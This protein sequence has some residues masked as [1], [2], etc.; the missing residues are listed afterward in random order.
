MKISAVK[1][2]TFF[3]AIVIFLQLYIYSFRFNIFFQLFVL[4]GFFALEK[5]KISTSFFKTS[6]PLII[7]FTLGF[8]GMV[9]E[10]Y[11]L[12]NI[13]KDIFHFIKPV[14]AICI[15]YFFYKKINNFKL[16]V[17]TIIIT[18][19][20]SALLHYIIIIFFIKNIETVSNI[21]EH[22]TDNFME[23]IA[24]FFLA[25]YKKF[26]KDQLFQ[27]KILHR[28]IFGVL[29]TSSVLYFSRTMIVMAVLTLLTIYGYTIINRKGLRIAALL[30]I[31]TLGFYAFLFSIN[32]QRNKKGIDS[33]LYKVKNAP[34]EVFKTRIDRENHADLWDHWRGYEANR[35]LTLLNDK[36]IRYFFGCG[37]GSLV[38]LKFYAPLSSDPKGM[39]YIS[40]L[41]NGYVYILY[42]IGI[43]G[44]LL[45]LLFL[46]NMYLKIYFNKDFV[47]IFISAIGLSF[48]FTTLVTVGINNSN[49]SL[50]FILGALLFFK[51]R[52]KVNS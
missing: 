9:F 20:I 22:G 45:Y 6:L 18:G 28:T 21:R 27:S 4:I 3:F 39:K 31:F 38:N 2:Y 8:I 13:I 14:L 50:M 24:I 16:F 10:R 46:F 26:Q 37:Y 36:P 17:K 19:F 40:E 5:V 35:A 32:I 51:E 44:L 52:Q 11:H 29:L 1:F 7:I 23:L 49:E 33:F 43:V 42:K 48:I 41:H 15:G 25:Y 12:Y 34:A 30:L 47:T